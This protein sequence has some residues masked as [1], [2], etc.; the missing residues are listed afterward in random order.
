MV[1]L[2]RFL[3][4]SLNKFND[5]RSAEEIAAFF[6]EKDNRG[7]DRTLA[8]VDDTIRG[9]A[10]YKERDAK[11]ILEWLKAHGY[12]WAPRGWAFRAH[13]LT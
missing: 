11:V 1:V 8:V 5:V 6:K 3:R 10:K 4:L 9:K 2:D 12:A 7:Y 13:E